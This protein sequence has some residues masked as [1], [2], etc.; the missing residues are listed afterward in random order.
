[1]YT[2]IVVAVAPLL[3]GI[4]AVV[5]AAIV[6]VLALRRYLLVL[7]VEGQSMSPTLRDGQRVLVRRQP[8]R[9]TVGD[10]VIFQIPGR[11]RHPRGQLIK[12]VAAVAGDP[13]PTCVQAAVRAR[14][15]ELVPE[16]SLVVFGDGSHST[17]SRDWGYL[18]DSDVKGVVVRRLGR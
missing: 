7:I 6:L 3:G 4:A 18:S 5:T 17:D 1:M 2:C 16:H 11:S 13:V 15:G 10:I 14:P 8:A 12:R 9:V